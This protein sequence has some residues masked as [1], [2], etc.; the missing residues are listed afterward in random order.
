MQ[1]YKH[2]PQI[3]EKAWGREI[4][5]WNNDDYCGKVLVFDKGTRTFSMHFHV[6]KH[7]TWYVAWGEF[8]FKGID[9]ENSQPYEFILKKGDVL[10]V[11]QG[12]C[13]QLIGLE[14]TNGI[15]EASTRDFCKDSYRVAPGD[16]Q[17][18]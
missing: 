3:V 8:R 14:E 12:Y 16:S 6:Q 17:K 1:L 5:F 18:V 15:F 7:E 9:P 13:H 11:F 10:P 2:E 4:I